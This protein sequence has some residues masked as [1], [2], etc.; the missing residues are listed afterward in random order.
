MVVVVG[1]MMI[2]TAQPQEL[3][4][5]AWTRPQH[6]HCHPVPCTSGITG[7]VGTGYTGVGTVVDS[8][9]WGGGLPVVGSRGCGGCA[10]LRSGKGKSK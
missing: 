7:G 5:G 9:A 8:G 1:V 2:R 6:G 3:T 4:Q 10:V